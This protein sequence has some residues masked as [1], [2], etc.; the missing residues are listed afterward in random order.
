VDRFVALALLAVGVVGALGFPPVFPNWCLPSVAAV[1]ALVA[2][3]IG[4]GGAGD[5]VRPLLQPIAFLVAAV[6]LAVLLD[7]LGFFTGLAARVTRG[8]GGAGHLWVMAA[9]VTTVLNLDA[10]VVLLTPL[11]VRVARERGWDVLGLAVQP[12]L[13]ACLAS[14]ALPVSNLTNLIVVAWDGA[15][16]G[17]FL[18]YLA[19]PSLVA[20]VVGWLFYKRAVG[21]RVA[22]PAGPP[23]ATEPPASVERVAGPAG[24]PDATEPPGSVDQVAVPAGPP[25]ATEPSARP[26]PGGF[27]S[28]VV[29]VGALLV[30]FTCGPLVGLQPWAVAVIADGVLVGLVAART[31]RWSL[32]WRHLPAGT[33]VVVL[34]LG[35]LAAGAGRYLP[36]ASLLRGSGPADLARDM[37]LAAAGANVVNNLPALLVALPHLGHHP[38]P[39]TWAVLLGVNTGPVIL[40]SG[41][42]ASLLWMAT[43]HRLGV[44]ARP[45]DFARFGATVGLP[46]T[47]CAL[48]AAIALRL[49][50]LN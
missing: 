14:C 29:V 32:P 16:T 1:A 36:L 40:V 31:G 41:S 47:A 12:V 13:L 23:A 27:R 11:Y 22:V 3:V 34:G 46:A 42:L 25:A 30:G 5:A 4:P 8:G 10:S 20:T 2:G 49:V 39:A 26:D 35:V 50:G 7:Q 33:A 48:G 21:A 17:Q 44:K 18:A 43:L 6:P 15:S 19:L 45:A 28:G 9:L 37:G 24:A 38:T